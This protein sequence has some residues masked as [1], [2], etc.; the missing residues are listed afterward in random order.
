[1]I[2]QPDAN[3]RASLIARIDPRIRIV[4]AA[5]L[6]IVIVLGNAS[7]PWA[8]VAALVLAL[9]ARLP[10]TNLMLR[11]LPLN[12]LMFVI[13]VTL[14][15]SVPGESMFLL[16]PLS[17]S[18]EGF[19]QAILIACKGNAVVITLT[20]LI[21]TIE[22]VQLGLALERLWVPHKL[23]RL[24]LFTVRYFSVIDSEF[25]RLSRAMMMRGFRPQLNLHTLRSYAYLA[26]MLLVHALDRSERILDAMRCRGFDGHFHPLHPKSSNFSFPDGVFI[27]ICAGWTVL[28]INVDYGLW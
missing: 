23:T 6:S 11:L 8:I 1:M 21:A 20:A 4:A 16:G 2:L 22:P 17:Y 28:L 25:N 24:F 19:G 7:A 15:F 5:V 10:I 14:P 18:F 13:V 12:A 9:L 27:A 26:G 3:L